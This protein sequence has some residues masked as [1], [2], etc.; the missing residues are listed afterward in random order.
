MTRPLIAVVVTG[1]LLV[2]GCGSDDDPDQDRATTTPAGGQV[3]ATTAAPTTTQT[4]IQTTTAATADSYRLSPEGRAVLDATQDLADD[5]S[6][7]GEEFVRGRIEQDEAVARLDLARERADDLRERA[8]QL[9]ASERASERLA[10][11]NEAI[12]RSATAISRD[13]SAGREA[14]RD[15]IERRIAQLRDEARSTFDAVTRQLDTQ[16]R[17]RLREALD[18]IGVEP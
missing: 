14:S 17:E 3:T 12:S 4:T 6:E 16:T 2:A 15:D 5:V 18:R 11:L 1:A 8:Q 9:P 13:V 10:S 7:T